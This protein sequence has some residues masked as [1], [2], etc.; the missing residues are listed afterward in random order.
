MK[1]SQRHER[2]IILLANNWESKHNAQTEWKILNLKNFLKSKKKKSNKFEKCHFVDWNMTLNH[3]P[4]F[5]GSE[6]IY[7]ELQTCFLW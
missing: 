6:C 7:S 5:Y 1:S 3:K 2:K 4:V